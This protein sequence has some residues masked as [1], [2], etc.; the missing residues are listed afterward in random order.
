MLEDLFA[1]PTPCLLLDR[2]RMQANADRLRQRVQ[3]L[4]A[5]LRPHVKTAKSLPIV[6]AMGGGSA[7]PV[8]VSTLAEAESCFAG[9]HRDV[10]Y[11]VGLSPSKLPAVLAL[12]ARG[13]DL[14][15]LVD[16][17]DAARAIAAANA[18]VPVLIEIDSD[19][20]RA[21]VRPDA[22]ALLAIAD[23]L[24]PGAALRGVMTHCGGAYDCPT[25][26]AIAAMAER[27]RLA[28]VTA[29][30]RLR[31]AGHPC[32]VVSVG[33]T[34]TATFA[35]SLVGVTEVRAGV[36]VFMDLVMV[37]LGVCRLDDLALSVLVRVIGHRADKPWLVT[38]G[39][40]MALSR[41]LGTQGHTQDRRY[42]LVCDV[43]GTPLDLVV[44]QTNQEHGLVARTDGAPFDVQRFPIGTPLRVLPVHAC[45]TAAQHDGYHVLEAG[46]VTAYWPR[47]RG[48]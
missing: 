5:T 39:G 47:V 24:R 1:L 40:W 42:G 29:A 4:G 35:R 30:E 13:C 26:D 25:T 12:R 10:L 36:H 15:V 44:A 38:D 23:A 2:A 14:S 32:P 8:T 27:E 3:S 17:V 33:S 11:A 16:H 43:H 18:Q 6:R 9:G 22:P 21:G 45:A 28:V 20:H 41:D 19:D 7:G 31:A 37:G 46:R 48:W 34:P